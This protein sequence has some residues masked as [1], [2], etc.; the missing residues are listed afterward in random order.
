MKRSDA[1]YVGLIARVFVLVIVVF[2]FPQKVLNDNELTFLLIVVP[3]MGWM[4]IQAYVD[5]MKG[6]WCL[7]IL[8]P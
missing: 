1:L 2:T 8:P 3:S 5:G 4:W 7:K 6:S